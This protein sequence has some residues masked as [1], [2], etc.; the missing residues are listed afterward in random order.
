MLFIR[1]ALKTDFSGQ[2]LLMEKKLYVQIQNDFY[3]KT[4]KKQTKLL[5]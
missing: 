4:M 1:Y 3:I 5:E 2:T